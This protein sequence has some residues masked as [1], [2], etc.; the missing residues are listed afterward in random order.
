MTHIWHIGLIKLQFLNN[1]YCSNLPEALYTMPSQVLK[2]VDMPRTH[3]SPTTATTRLSCNDRSSSTFGSPPVPHC[4]LFN[5][6]TFSLVEL[7]I[8]DQFLFASDTDRLT[9]LT[10]HISLAISQ[11]TIHIQRP[12]TT[13]TT[14]YGVIHKECLQ[15]C[16]KNQPLPLVHKFLVSLTHLELYSSRKK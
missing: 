11:I 1:L 14:Q 15:K 4:S 2:P 5:D 12:Y 3:T 6:S 7:F 8:C 9:L 13:A 10:A 16:N